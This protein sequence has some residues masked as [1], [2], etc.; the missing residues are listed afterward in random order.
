MRCA[1]ARSACASRRSSSCPA[2]CA[3]TSSTRC[4]SRTRAA[5]PTRS[6]WRRCSAPTTAAAKRTSKLVDWSSPWQ[7]MRWSLRT[8]APGGSI[9]AAGRAA[10]GDPRRGRGHAQA[11]GGPLR[12][13]RGD[14]PH[15]L[16]QRGDGGGDPLARRALGRARAAG[17]ARGGG[18]PAARA[19]P[20][21]RPDRRDL[22]RRRRGEGGA[23]GRAAAA[24]ALV[25]PRARRRLPGDLPRPRVLGVA[26]GRR[27]VA[28]GARATWCCAPTTSGSTASPRRSRG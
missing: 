13:R 16:P 17:R 24:R 6:G 8:V 9:R 10:P 12:P 11:H 19:D 18:D 26:R 25:R 20:L 4:C 1:R 27:R 23:Q 15:A 28:L 21:P 5:R 7:A 14:R 22:P 3:P 2:R